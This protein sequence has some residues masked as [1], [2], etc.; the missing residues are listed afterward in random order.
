M[1]ILRKKISLICLFKVHLHVNHALIQRSSPN[2]LPHYPV[3]LE[4][5]QTAISPHPALATVA[6]ATK[7][8]SI[9]NIQ[10]A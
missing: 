8:T 7:N 9:K 10:P 3:H 1:D 5:C 6:P 2:K 4:Q